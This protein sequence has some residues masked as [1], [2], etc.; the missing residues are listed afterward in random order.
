MLESNRAVDA[1]E[2]NAIMPVIAIA[3]LSFTDV[4]A[5][6][7]YQAR[8]MDVFNR[9][10]GQLLAADEKPTLIEGE[11]CPDKV[12]I[13]RFPSEADFHAWADSADYQDISRD[14]RAGASATILLVRS[15][16][17]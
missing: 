5:Y 6:R 11:I 13:M 14:R 2:P 4:D 12:V 7:R 3:Q 1:W 17:G 8:F 15:I 9:F 10:S 16:A